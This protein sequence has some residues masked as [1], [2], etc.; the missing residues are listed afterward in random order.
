MQK[1]KVSILWCALVA[2]IFATTTLLTSVATQAQATPHTNQSA[3]ALVQGLV[4]TTTGTAA[5]TFNGILTLTNFAVQ[6]GQIVAQGLLTRTIT[7]QDG[8]TSQVS[9][10]VSA[11]ITAAAASCPIL[12]LP[13]GP[14][15]LNVLGLVINLNQVYVNITAQS[16]AGNLLG[17]LLCDVAN[18]LNNGGALSS[19]VA[20]LN[21]ILKTL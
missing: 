4:S 8:T 6:N 9:Q 10:A 12:S 7:N 11:P 13:L 14:L 5:G 3:S 20:D 16:G 21:A 1:R 2:A 15:H 17:N 19:I 18:L